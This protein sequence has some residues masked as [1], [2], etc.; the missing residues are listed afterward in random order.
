MKAKLHLVFSI[1]IIFAC[2]SSYGQQGY[3]KS[4]SKESSFKSASVKNMSKAGA[5]FSLNKTAFEKELQ[6]LSFLKGQ[7]K[8]TYF[9]VS[10]NE[11]VAFALEETPLL[12][13]ELAKKFPKIKSYSGLS[14]DGKFKIK[15]S[16]S[17]KGLQ[18]MV[19]NVTD[20]KTIFMEKVSNKTDTYIL[21]EKGS[22]ASA[23]E[24][25]VCET[26]KLQSTVFKTIVPLVDDQLLRRYRIAVSASGEYTQFHG[27]TVADALAAINATLTRVNQVFE[28][29]LGVTLE[30]VPNNDLVI[31]TN[32]NTDPYTSNLNGEVQNTLTTTIGE[33]NY[34]V[35]HLFH[36]VGEGEDNGNAGFIGAVCSDNQKGSAF[37]A[38]FIPQGDVF[39]FDYVSHELGHQFGANHTWSFESEG[40]GVQAEPA[41]GTTIMGYAGIVGENN[42]APNG[43]D[44]FHYYS[45]LQITNYLQTTSCAQTVAL[46][47]SPPVVTPMGDYII[48][49][50]TAFVLEGLAIDPDPGDVL[51]YTWEQI[52]NGVVTTTTFGPEN[53]SSANFR[54]LPPSV[55]PAR[56]FPGLS[57]VIQ[58]N[59]TQTN[60]QINEAWETVSNV[61]RDL[62]FALTVRDNASGGGQV[63]SDVLNVRV[64]N[65]AGPFVVTSQTSAEV[66]EAGSIQEITWDVANTNQS[67]IDAQMV[68]IYLST[69]GGTGFPILLADDTLNDG[70]EDVLIPGNV[71]SGARVMVKASN[72]VFFA[73]N[74]SNFSIQ[75]DEVVLAFDSLDHEVCQ[76]ND[77]TIP[78]AYQ[79]FDG[80]NETSTF[81]ADVPA[82]LT[83]LFSPVDA[84][85]DDT[86][87]DLTLSNTN[88]V[89][90]GIYDITVTSTSA[91][92]TKEVVLSV[93]IRDTGFTD[94]V[95]TSPVDGAAN[96]SL[97]AQ[98]SWEADPLY[99]GYD[100]EVATDVGFSSIVASATVPFNFYLATDL[101]EQ[102][103][104]FWRVRPNN[105]CGTG[106]FG[107][108]FSFTTTQVECKSF[109]GANN[110]PLEIPA[111]G[112]PTV[113]TSIQFFEDLVISDLNVNLELTHS[114]L[115][116]LV[117]SLI[118]PAGTR[119]TLVANT[120][121]DLNDIN[122]IFDDD[123]AQIT[124]SGNPAIS[125]TVSPFGSLASLNGESTLGEW[126]LEIRDIFESDGGSLN[127]F[128]LDIC[129]EG[130]FRPDEDEDGVFD[131]GDDLCLGTPKGTEVDVTGCPI[132][133]FPADNFV[134]EIQSE[135][136]R[137]NNDGS[138]TVTASDTSISSTAVLN[139]AG[140]TLNA[141]F[142]NAHTFQNIGAGTYTLCINGTNGMTTFQETCFEIIVSEPEVLSVDA[143]IVDS[144][145]LELTL[146]GGNFYNIELNGLVAQTE[147]SKIKIPLAQ[148]RNSL[149]VYTNLPCQGTFE[150]NFFFSSKPILYPNPV[151]ASSK[152]FLN[153]FSGTVGIEVFSMDGKLAMTDA[154]TVNGNELELDFSVLSSGTYVLKVKTD[155]TTETFKLIKR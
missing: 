140:T 1:T 76:P 85:S 115:E 58:G 122:A 62:N 69:D 109:D 73:V 144:G 103:D 150:D 45:I 61:E 153:G 65:A 23:K 39:D 112:T 123:G 82:G 149:K 53:P 46:T 33:A 99:S 71:T 88:N 30:L 124:C 31:F 12:S 154:K 34:D 55:N 133:R 95:L 74:D 4:I 91:S 106:T 90:P 135:A 132:N 145:L 27:G 134:V 126:I 13:E 64:I 35:G 105:G 10:E 94:V 148:G 26:A 72:N 121:G 155:N 87:V 11:M 111:V 67:P 146:D 9:P 96:V 79:T 6:Q 14:L 50:G 54:S 28:T 41:S 19:V 8:V 25:F 120:C 107:T 137:S 38:A 21:Y 136:C 77:I 57:E 43:D 15:L 127:S 93:A 97:N 131:D 5:A 152:I 98:L 20:K 108:P 40:T 29:D 66:Y 101:L 92:V 117:I 114:Y 2:F 138:V 22:G 49:K 147:E 118:S 139:G 80:F 102:T 128:S 47:N 130:A 17:H 63:I 32:P 116:D 48:P 151:V 129:A 42:V 75:Q 52:D 36:K 37:S 141:D 60:P 104:Y 3:W 89:A 83:A 81:S 143:L 113:S 70:M 142:T 59:L 44:Y 119:V 100:V 86:T 16:G 84:T 125:G 51:T 24:D 18:G 110:L 7:K 68:D 56:Y 78:F